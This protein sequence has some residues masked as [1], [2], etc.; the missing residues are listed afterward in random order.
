MLSTI[1][2][3]K[4]KDFDDLDQLDIYSYPEDITRNYKS[5]LINE[6]IQ[7]HDHRNQKS[8]T[9]SSKKV[10]NNFLICIPIFQKF[11]E[12]NFYSICINSKMIIGLIFD[13]EDNPYDYKEIF[14]DLSHELLNN[15]NYCSFEDEIEIENFL[16]T[17]FIDLR[18]YGDE[19]LEKYSETIVQPINKFTKVFLSGIDEVGKSSLIRRLKTGQFDDNFF[20]PTRKFDIEYI[21]RQNNVLAFWDIPGQISFREKW[22]KGIQDSNILVYMIDIANQLRFKESKEE[23]WKVISEETTAEIPILILGNKIDL[24][25]DSKNNNQEQLKRLRNEIINYF[26]FRDLKNREWEFLFTSVKTNFNINDVLFTI[27]NLISR[28]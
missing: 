20:T 19:I 7:G 13:N 22:L 14:E 25:N 26:D 9:L 2:L 18:R 27:F 17:L 1:F 4:G 24:I 15:E 5:N 23:F 11:G 8:N 3:I 16:I 28:N 6:L 12:K 10:Q 21:Q